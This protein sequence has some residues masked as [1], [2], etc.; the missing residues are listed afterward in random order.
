MNKREYLDQLRAALGCLPEEEI[1][2]SL[3]FYAEMIDDRVADGMSEEESTAQLDEPKAAARA[4]IGGL[5]VEVREA[6]QVFRQVQAASSQVAQPNTKPKNRA[7]YWTLAVLG[8]PLWLA[9]LLAVAAIVAAAI[10]S[11]AV[12]VAVLVFALWALAA[13]LLAAGPLGVAVC[14]YGLAMGQPA[15]AAAELGSDLICF[16]LGLFCLHGAVVATHGASR[17]W[18]AS[19]TKTKAWLAKARSKIGG[20][21]GPAAKGAEAFIPSKVMIG[22]KEAAHEA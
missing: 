20:E 19:V 18:Q 11:V 1:E 12:T 3:A 14:F 9:L 4:I 10:L 15:Y 16:G 2:E 13:A 7:L 22:A 6:S 5:P 8:S 17:L 21:G